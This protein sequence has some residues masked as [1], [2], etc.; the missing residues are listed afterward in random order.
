MLDPRGQLHCFWCLKTNS[1]PP[2]NT[3]SALKIVKNKIELRKLWPLKVEGSR[4]QKKKQTT[5]CYKGR[6][7]KT[8]K[9]P[10]MLF[11]CY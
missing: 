5:K 8:H 6:F 1:T 3:S 11:F 10:C 4:T 7:P 9:I 2:I